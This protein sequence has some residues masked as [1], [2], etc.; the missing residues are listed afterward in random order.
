MI[1]VSLLCVMVEMCAA[2][3][4][5]VSLAVNDFDAPTTLQ[6]HI[7][8]LSTKLPQAS[9]INVYHNL[10]EIGVPSY[11]M[12]VNASKSYLRTVLNGLDD[13]EYTSWFQLTS[14]DTLSEEE[15]EYS[16]DTMEE[17]RNIVNFVPYD[18]SSNTISKIIDQPLLN[19]E[20]QCTI[21]YSVVEKY[22]HKKGTQRKMMKG[23]VAPV[24][25]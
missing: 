9:I 12:E 13:L 6:Q 18:S 10:A 17:M 24:S 21:E 1:F 23:Q 2:S 5:L 25:S 11:A 16:S 15:D 20:A 7:S 4:F 14:S 19:K 8:A 22:R 3:T